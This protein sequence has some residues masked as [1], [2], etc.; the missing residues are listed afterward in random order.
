MKTT[1]LVALTTTIITVLAPAQAIKG[2]M[3]MKVINPP[4]LANRFQEGLEFVEI[5]NGHRLESFDEQ[6]DI[7]MLKGENDN[8]CQ[9][10]HLA[11]VSFSIHF[12][13]I[14]SNFFCKKI[15]LLGLFFT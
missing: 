8:G 6:I 11:E 1:A 13:F 10:F 9:R 5:I 12:S 14:I 7:H 15:I 3:E 4:M 2:K